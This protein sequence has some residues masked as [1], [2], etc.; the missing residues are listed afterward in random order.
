MNLQNTLMETLG[1]ELVSLE[2]DLV[3]IKMPVN[4][5]THQPMGFLHG[6]ASVALAES[7]ASIGAYVNVDPDTQQIFGLEINA[8]HMKSKRDGWV[9]G[10]AT[11]LHRGK[12]TMVWE[13]K[14]VDETDDLIS[15]SRCTVGVVPKKTPE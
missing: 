2:K 6:G 9:T 11:P 10:K 5:H 7:A 13:I 4:K 1:M 12:T 15:I 3:E 8:N 14:I